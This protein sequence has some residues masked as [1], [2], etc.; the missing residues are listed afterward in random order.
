MSKKT[1]V[2]STA[3]TPPVEN[4]KPKSG[5]A[6]PSGP[7]LGDKGK[8]KPSPTTGPLKPGKGKK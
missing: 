8:K 1:N 6:K 7:V 2:T 4:M 3:N 5:T